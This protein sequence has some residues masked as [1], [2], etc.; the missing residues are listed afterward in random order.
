MRSP[1][2]LD[3]QESSHS[4]IEKYNIR[5][6]FDDEG[7]VVIHSASG[8]E[9]NQISIQSALESL[10]P[11]KSG[12]FAVTISQPGISPQ[13]FEGNFD[14][15]TGFN[16]TGITGE[17]IKLQQLFKN[18]CKKL[19]G[20]NVQFQINN[21]SQEK[22]N[23]KVEFEDDGIVHSVKSQ[24]LNQNSIQAAFESLAPLKRGKFS[25]EIAQQ[26][27]PPQ[28]FKGTF[29]TTKGF[30]FQITLG[31]DF[32][33]HEFFMSESKK[34]YGNNI[35]FNSPDYNYH[36]LSNDQKEIFIHTLLDCI[37]NGDNSKVAHMLKMQTTSALYDVASDAK[38]IDER[39]RHTKFN[40]AEGFEVLSSLI[41]TQ[42]Y[43]LNK[44]LTHELDRWEDRIKRV[45]KEDKWRFMQDQEVGNLLS[46]NDPKNNAIIALKQELLSLR[47]EIA[48]N[49]IEDV[50]ILQMRILIRATE[51]LQMHNQKATNPLEKISQKITNPA[52][53]VAG[54]NNVVQELQNT[55][56]N[57]RR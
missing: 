37:K 21:I 13:I 16:F 29:D 35:H 11:H 10:A 48:L 15:K 57:F 8:Q 50:E 42:K 33:L 26:D 18:E 30:D 40:D 54:L 41:T 25:I 49:K 9:L 4:N 6:D 39:L 38:R 2:N 32:Q 23:I 51:T 36:K 14:T 45:L 24:Q 44:E 31:G 47:K 20:N 27:M 52:V 17:N 1:G 3:N 7:M 53:D 43:A 5:V 28:I 19:Y 12:K 56:R 34:I 46:T 55:A 22:F